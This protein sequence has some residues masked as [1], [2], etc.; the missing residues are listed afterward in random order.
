MTECVERAAEFYLDRELHRQGA[1]YDPW[2]RFH[3]PVHYYYD[4]LVGLDLLTALGF[5]SDPRLRYA[6]LAPPRKATTGRALEPRGS[7]S[8]CGGG[9][10]RMVPEAP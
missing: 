3:D 2:Y 9:H 1:R 6:L 4:L 8:G 10:G 7:P 5:G